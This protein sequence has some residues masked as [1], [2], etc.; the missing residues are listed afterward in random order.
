MTLIERIKEDNLAARKNRDQVRATLL[1]T[2]FSEA[3]SVGKNAGNRETTDAETLAVIKKFI[4]GIDDTLSAMKD[5]TDPRYV[6]ACAERE[7]LEQYR[8]L[9][10]NEQQL[11][12]IL[13]DMV[14]ALQERTPKQMGVIMKRLKETYEGQYDGALAS[15]LIKELLA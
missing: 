3:V 11:Q 2:L 13:H 9:Q 1:T 10:L 6:T 12:H 5:K 8:P 7:I 14:Q 15:K 4:K